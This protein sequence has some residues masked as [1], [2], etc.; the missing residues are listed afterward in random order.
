MET[1]KTTAAERVSSTGWHARNTRTHFT[2]II[3]FSR[4]LQHEHTQTPTCSLHV[5]AVC[6][7][8]SLNAESCAAK[9]HV[10]A[11]LDRYGE[12]PLGP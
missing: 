7:I 11:V 12:M 4:S 10:V 8:N 6:G 3:S 1:L 9:Q 2:H 5:A